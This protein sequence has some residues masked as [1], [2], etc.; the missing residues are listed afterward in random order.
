MKLEF[1]HQI[2]KVTVP[3]FMTIRRVGAEWFHADRQTDG[4]TDRQT[5][6]LADMTKIIIY[7]RSFAKAPKNGSPAGKR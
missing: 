3:N 6:G 7:F 5:A 4:Q 2:K 1:S